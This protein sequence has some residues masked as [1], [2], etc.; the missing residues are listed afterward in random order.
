MGG[1]L[2]DDY[3]EDDGN[4]GV[5]VCH[6]RREQVAHGLFGL[7]LSGVSAAFAGGAF[8]P[9]PAGANPGDPPLAFAFYGLGACVT[10]V[11]AIGLFIKA[12]RH[13]P[14]LVVN[15]YG[16]LDRCSEDGKRRQRLWR[17]DEIASV[18]C[19]VAGNSDLVIQTLVIN[20]FKTP[21]AAARAEMNV[22]PSPLAPPPFT[23]RIVHINQGDLDMSV[24][25]L[26]YAIEL[27]I[28][29]Y[30][31][32]GWHGRLSDARRELV[33]ATALPELPQS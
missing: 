18:G 28:T 31:P 13:R 26:A 2:P 4:G 3:T 19:E 32:A 8:L 29:I 6:N 27:Y 21:A 22:I 16:I 5:V 24:I 9:P 12:L 1:D 7:M 33:H 15:A 14:A 17:W 25:E 30:K 11:P 23:T 20:V 10:G